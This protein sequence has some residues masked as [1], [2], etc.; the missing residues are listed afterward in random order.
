MSRHGAVWRWRV[1][2]K[3]SERDALVRSK[4][5]GGSQQRK[6]SRPGPKPSITR[7]VVRRVSDRVAR[8]LTLALALAAEGNS[9]INVETWKKALGAHPEFS[10]LYEAGKGKFLERAT[11]RLAESDQLKHLCW[12]LER[13]HPDLFR[14]PADVVVN[15]DV[16]VELPAD[17][18]ERARD[19]AGNPKSE[20][21]NPKAN[22]RD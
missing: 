2:R 8:G 3:R 5:S 18:L 21:R 11:R 17:L 13:R 1:K 14:K 22:G 12:L 19:L 6:R 4:T 20:T 7:A 16:R 10:P 9:T 15:N